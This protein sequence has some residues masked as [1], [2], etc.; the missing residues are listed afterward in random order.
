MKFE[1]TKELPSLEFDE[2]IGHL[3]I[4]G[5]SISI[6]AADFWNPLIEKMKIYLEDPRD[7][8]LEISL[9]YFNTTSSKKLLDL[10]NVI[11]KEHQ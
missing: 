9:E 8:H 4:S 11:D 1:G 6:E 7:I 5:I 3:K 2:V 10:L